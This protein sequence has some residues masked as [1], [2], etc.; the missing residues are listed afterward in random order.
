V[1][2][3]RPGQVNGAAHDRVR[4]HSHAACLL[5]TAVWTLAAAPSGTAL[6]C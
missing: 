6:S 3:G 5:A 1:T 2:P 4:D